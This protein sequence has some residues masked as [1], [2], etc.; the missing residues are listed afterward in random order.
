MIKRRER[1]DGYGAC[2]SERKSLLNQ[3]QASPLDGTERRVSL[4]TADRVRAEL[5]CRKWEA[6]FAPFQP[7][8]QGVEFPEPRRALLPPLPT[9]VPEATKT[10][11]VAAPPTSPAAPK[12]SQQPLTC[13]EPDPARA[14]KIDLGS[15]VHRHAPGRFWANTCSRWTKRAARPKKR[16]TSMKSVA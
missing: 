16:Q 14:G 4:Q 2:L 13:V 1:G 10:E 6:C 5:L 11:P 15:P 12:S 7:E 9:F 3:A 8:F